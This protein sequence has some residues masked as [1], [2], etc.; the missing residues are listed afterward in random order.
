MPGSRRP[1]WKY[2][3]TYSSCHKKDCFI[4]NL[5]FKGISTTS[6]SMHWL[7]CTPVI[8]PIHGKQKAVVTGS[9][10][11][12]RWR[13]CA[14]GRRQNFPGCCHQALS[15]NVHLIHKQDDTL[16]IPLKEKKRLK[17]FWHMKLSLISI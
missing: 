9:T 13:R 7:I 10:Q 11:L 15:T 4:V 12:Q 5:E 3:L 6:S 16:Q 1:T 14:R 17:T 2:D 8:L